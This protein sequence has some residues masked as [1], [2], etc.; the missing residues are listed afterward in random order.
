MRYSRQRKV[1]LEDL[2]NRKDHPTA[3]MVYQSVIKEVPKIG[4]AT[5]YRNLNALVN[6][7]EILR[8]PGM[9]LPDRFDGNANKHYHIRCRTCG[10]IEDIDPVNETMFLTAEKS[11]KNSFGFAEEDVEFGDVLFEYN[12]VN[13][14]LSG[15]IE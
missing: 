11:I 15:Y 14:R 13:C 8:I 3:E 1:I 9:D 12:C 5:V 7:G 4:I 6:S 2:K 10:K